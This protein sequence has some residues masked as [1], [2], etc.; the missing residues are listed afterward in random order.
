[1]EPE[2]S[3]LCSQKL[4][5]RPYPETHQFSPYHPSYLSEIHYDALLLPTSRSSWWTLSFSHQNLICIRL[6]PM[7]ASFPAHPILLD[8]ITLIMLGEEYK[9]WSSSLCSFHQPPITSSLFEPNILLST[10][11]ANILSLCSSLNVRNQVSL[12]HNTTWCKQYVN[13]S[14]KYTTNKYNLNTGFV[15]L[16]N[17]YLTLWRI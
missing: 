12:P 5:T 8:L 7:H 1:M 11:F 6:L 10:L 17:I 3:L 13:K 16:R 15:V 9:L 14:K 4:P 2:G